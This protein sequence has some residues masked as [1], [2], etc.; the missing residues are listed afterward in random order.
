VI[1]TGVSAL[2]FDNSTGF[3]APPAFG[4]YRVLHQ[5]GSGVLGPVFRTFE[6]NLEKLV[7]VKA[8][9]LDV[10]P[11]VSAQLAEALRQLAVAPVRHAGVVPVV[12]A[13]LEGATAFLAYEY[14]AA[15]T[16]DVTLRDMAPLSLDAALPLLR[17]VAA[18][19]EAAWAAGQGHGALHPRDIFVTGGSRA[20]SSALEVRVA[21]FG[22]TAALEAL[23]IAAPV[24]RPYSAPERSVGGAWDRRSDTYSL[25]VIAHELLTGRRPAGPGL[26]D[27]GLSGVT[28]EQEVLIRQA[29]SGAL[30]VD[31]AGRFAS[32][33]VFVDAL[34]AAGPPEIATVTE[35]TE[36]TEQTFEAE[37]AEA[38][39]GAASEPP[40]EEPDADEADEQEFVHE[41]EPERELVRESSLTPVPP[42]RSPEPLSVPPVVAAPASDRVVIAWAMAM[43]LVVAA[44]LGYWFLGGATDVTPA[45]AVL[46]DGPS[47]TEVPV[48]EPP[49][50]PEPSPAAPPV[51]SVP[52]PAERRGRLLIRSVPAGAM[53]AVNGRARGSTPAALRDLPFGTYNIAVTHPGYQRRTQRL[54][55]SQAVPA[56][57]VTLE[58][59]Q[60]AAPASK[61]GTGSIYVETRPAGATVSIDGRMVGTAPMRVPELAPGPHAVR[62]DLAGHKSMTTTAV[63]RAGQQSILRVSLEVRTPGE[64]E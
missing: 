37:A 55:V 22:V 6:P 61:V 28:P 18:A 52:A 58:L 16:L 5:I 45:V 49:V 50:V 26:G 3:T 11:E 17:Q 29:L 54:T 46:D 34:V 8:F 53:V 32:P 10:V 42:V 47:G 15:D 57:E 40:R 30:Q 4:P 35:P 20:G 2:P 27:E 59:A 12:D 36:S 48:A 38:P 14:V 44:G 7:A 31:P 9:R 19:L 41:G 23:G 25:G 13:G 60:A 33:A 51:A 56:R 43:A 39:V 62:V 63:V 24:R 1:V 21:G 64:D